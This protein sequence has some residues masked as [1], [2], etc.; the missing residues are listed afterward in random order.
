MISRE[1][2][3]EILEVAVNAPS[4]E[5]SQPW[6]FIVRDNT[7]L[8]INLPERDKSLYNFEQRG[9][10]VSNGALIENIVIAAAYHNVS[11][12]VDI[13]PDA[14]NRDLVAKIMFEGGA[15]DDGSLYPFITARTTNRKP[16]KRNV[17]T[18]GQV[19]ALL[20]ATKSLSEGDVR[21][22]RD[23]E[24]IK[25]LA[26]VGSVNEKVMF[27]NRHLH[28]FFF[29]HINWTKKEDIEKRV[30]FYIKTLELPLPIQKILPL[31]RSW[32]LIALFNRLGFNNLIAKGNMKVYASSSAMG[33]VLIDDYSPHNMILAG[34]ILQRVWLKATAMDLSLQ[35]LTG[36]AFFA[37]RVKAKDVD[38]FSEEQITLIQAAYEKIAEIFA[39]DK[40]VVPL[41][42]RIGY[43][44]NPTA[45]ALKL[46]PH[47]S[48]E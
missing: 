26:E 9:S 16:Y 21:F 34:R 17:L 15:I 12:S 11:A 39:I 33:V 22:V 40:K 44:K 7:L 4:G 6:R 43:G 42:F 46:E 10:L 48:Y 8:V 41:M 32:R 37:Q 24:K 14:S 30:G 31:F 5:N 19:D 25:V 1:L 45:H 13:L 18:D 47:I 3:Q 35:P 2:I 38:K 20:A 23:K 27:D 29:S 36:V 28:G